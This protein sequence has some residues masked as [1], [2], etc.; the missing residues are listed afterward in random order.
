MKSDKYAKSPAREGRKRIDD[1]VTEL[2]DPQF[3]QK[4]K[5]S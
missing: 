5:K 3:R 4:K 1:P 2:V